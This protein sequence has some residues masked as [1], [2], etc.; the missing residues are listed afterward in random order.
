MKYMILY[1]KE[2]DFMIKKKLLLFMI[3]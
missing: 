1:L 3:I 2:N